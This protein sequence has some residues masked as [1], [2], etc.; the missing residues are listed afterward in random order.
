MPIQS[1]LKMDTKNNQT[2][3][4][5]TLI[6]RQSD[7]TGEAINISG[8][9]TGALVGLALGGPVG[10]VLGAAT[11]PVVVMTARV[12]H[13]VL[14]RKRMRGQAVVEQALRNARMDSDFAITILSD[15]PDKTDD[16]ISLLRTIAESDPSI[17]VVVAA[18]LSETLL[19]DNELKRERLRIIGDAI[20]HLRGTHLHI[21]RSLQDAGGQL[22]ASEIASRIGIPEIEL[23]SVVRDLELRG[24]IKDCGLHPIEWKL[25]EL[26]SSV[27]AFAH[28]QGNH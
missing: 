27:V 11:Q 20:R 19:S 28:Q 9:V 16:F 17:D 2:E 8:A 12:V 3:R 13:D 4:N 24:M 23:R 15:D 5:S 7:L 1:F 26:G 22:P 6:Q 14:E 10:S 25:R 21:L 18:L